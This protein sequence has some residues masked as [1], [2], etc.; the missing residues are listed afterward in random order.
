MKRLPEKLSPYTPIL[1]TT[2][3]RNI[4]TFQELYGPILTSNPE[5]QNGDYV[6]EPRSTDPTEPAKFKTRRILEGYP[7][8]DGE[9]KVA[10]GADVVF[11]NGTRHLKAEALGSDL[12]ATLEET[13]A[14]YCTDAFIVHWLI[15]FV[16][17]TEDDFK[18]VAV[19]DVE[20]RYLQPL[21]EVDVRAAFNP[22]INARIPLVERGRNGQAEFT[23]SN[24]YRDERVPISQELAELLVV[25]RVLPVA[26]MES[27]VNDRAIEYEGWEFVLLKLLAEQDFKERLTHLLTTRKQRF[28]SWVEQMGHKIKE[29]IK[30]FKAK[31]NLPNFIS[32]L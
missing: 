28:S 12:I 23:L 27:L 15:A 7:V 10:F 14:W 24:S 32:R 16:V 13:V 9:K 18:R 17:E 2:K 22:S 20:G 25:D 19:L 8:P 31:F 26:M 11:V 4:V 21:E 29:R 5:T 6:P 3:E 30:S 1:G